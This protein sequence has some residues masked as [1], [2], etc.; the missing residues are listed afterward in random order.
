VQ[1][2]QHPG[3]QE[4]RA[5]DAELPARVQAEERALVVVLSMI[6]VDK[7]PE[8]EMLARDQEKL[9]AEGVLLDHQNQVV[10][11]T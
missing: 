8:A 4:A 11:L 9:P 10:E 2:A 7:E 3:T 1:Y 6:A 5:G